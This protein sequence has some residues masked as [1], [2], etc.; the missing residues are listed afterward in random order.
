M[1]YTT[2]SFFGHVMFSVFGQSVTHIAW[3]IF[4]FWF[5]K[6]RFQ[7]V[8]TTKKLIINISLLELP[9]TGLVKY[10]YFKSN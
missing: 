8:F 9:F 10:Q 2:I 7:N 6:S 1:V 3:G 4:F 5:Y